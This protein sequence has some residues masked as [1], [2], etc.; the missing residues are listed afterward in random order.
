MVDFFKIINNN[1]KNSNYSPSS[2]F[3]LSIFL[4]PLIGL[5]G[6]LSMLILSNLLKTDQIHILDFTAYRELN[7]ELSKQ[8]YVLFISFIVILSMYFYDRSHFKKFFRIGNIFAPTEALSILGIKEEHTWKQ[9]GP[10]IVLLL[11]AGTAIFMAIGVFQMKGIFNETVLRLFPL[12]LIFSTTNAWSEEI[13]ARFTIV[14]GLDDKVK[15]AIKYWVSAAVFGIPHYF[16]TPGGL[17]GVFMA[18]FLGWLLAKSIHETK[19]MFWAW[20]I[21]FIQD[22]VI[23]TANLMILVGS[24]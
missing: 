20:L 18:G 15:P 9:V 7:I 12:S 21:H 17:I 16:G 13:F 3:K 22:V 8:I 24:M 5:T 23:F 14:A 19:G 2:I 1:R 11:T 6:I 10:I 4:P